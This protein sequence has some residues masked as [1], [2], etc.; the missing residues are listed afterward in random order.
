MDKNKKEKLKDLV[1]IGTKELGEIAE[2]LVKGDK[3]EH[4]RN[5]LSDLSALC[6]KPML[7]LAGMEFDY[8]VEVGLIRK[9]E[10]L[11]G[12]KKVFE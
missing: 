7:E 1:I 2:C 5:E 9:L 3:N 11:Q 12:N 10:K 8:A 4:W 6:I